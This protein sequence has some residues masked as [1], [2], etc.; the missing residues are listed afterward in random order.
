M[1]LDGSAGDE[2][3]V[4]KYVGV[5]YLMSA[6]TVSIGMRQSVWLGVGCSLPTETCQPPLF[7]SV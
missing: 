1:S 7:L 5:S 4:S 6:A 3:L 2:L